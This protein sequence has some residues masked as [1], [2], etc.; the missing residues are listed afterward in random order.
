[1]DY[2]NTPEGRSV[3]SKYVSMAKY[4]MLPARNRH[5]IIPEC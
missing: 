5:I 3:Q 2:K 1:M 4:S